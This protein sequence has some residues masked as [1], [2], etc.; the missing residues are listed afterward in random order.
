MVPGPL[1]PA[2]DA[3]SRRARRDEA[4]R[5]VRRRRLRRVGLGATFVTVTSVSW[6]VLGHM[7]RVGE[8]DVEVRDAT[9]DTTAPPTDTAE[10]TGPLDEPGGL[11]TGPAGIIAASS[12]RVV[13]NHLV[14]VGDSVLQAAAPLVPDAL[15]GWSIVAD[16]RVGRFLPEATKVLER[17]SEDLGEVVV[18]NLG[19][20]YSGDPIAFSAEVEDAMAELR[21]VD[22]VIWINAGEFEPAQREVNSVLRAALRR[23]RNLVLLDWNTIWK[24]HR[25][26]YTGADD[27]HLTPK[28]AEAYTAMI[29]EA[30][31]RVAELANIEPAPGPQKPIITTKGSV[32]TSSGSSGSNRGT[33]RRTT[34]TVPA[35]DHSGTS[36]PEVDDGSGEGTSSD[37][38]GSG[39][40]GS[41]T[42]DAHPSPTA[43][44]P[45]TPASPN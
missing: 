41:G 18:L 34:S 24:E 6:V 30:V 26:S 17:R 3:S 37:G 15:P 16:T 28:G 36:V 35:G 5:A 22:H 27:L 2:P 32:P 45:T 23:H 43:P 13:D 21:E 25:K 44:A 11:I 29:A 19:N 14:L 8:L 42:P 39:S 4:R 38:S 31:A 33:G 1:T 9:L 7:D 20:N 12:R 40:G 10:P